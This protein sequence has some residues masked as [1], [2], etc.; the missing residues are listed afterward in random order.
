MEPMGLLINTDES[1]TPGASP[2]PLPV[3]H[4]H[5]P[6]DIFSF[7]AVKEAALRDIFSYED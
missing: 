7:S 2:R 5:P 3:R 1:M 6:A 4:F